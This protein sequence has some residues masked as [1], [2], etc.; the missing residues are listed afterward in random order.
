MAIFATVTNY[1]LAGGGICETLTVNNSF[2][3]AFANRASPLQ[4][5]LSTHPTP[6][7][8]SILDMWRHL[9][10]VYNDA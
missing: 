6:P 2:A 5:H 3:S 7:P 8:R 10:V 9:A 4:R 1:N